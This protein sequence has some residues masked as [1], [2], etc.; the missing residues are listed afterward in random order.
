MESIPWYRTR[1]FWLVVMVI[2]AA[3]SVFFYFWNIFNP[4]ALNLTRILSDIFFALGGTLFMLIGGW[5]GLI[6]YFSIQSTL[7]W[8]TFHTKTV[9]LRYPILILLLYITGFAT[10]IIYFSGL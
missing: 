3:W 6:T 4:N 5:F 9:K 2:I 10:S 1:T 7:L 8:L